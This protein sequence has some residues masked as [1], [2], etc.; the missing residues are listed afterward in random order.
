M[1]AEGKWMHGIGGKKE[2]KRK[3]RRVEGKTK[4][5]DGRREKI[6]EGKC[7]G[8]LGRIGVETFR[9]TGGVEGR[10]KCGWKKKEEANRRKGERTE[11]RAGG[12]KEE[13]G[14]GRGGRGGKR[15]QEGGGCR[16]HKRIEKGMYRYCIQSFLL[17]T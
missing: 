9:L 15:K 17:N 13:G 16:K 6:G 4:V 1:K 3:E 5:Y 7:G 10:G 14:R 2:E 11:N 12:R 8:Y